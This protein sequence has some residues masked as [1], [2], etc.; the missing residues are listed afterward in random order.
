MWL[1][2][3]CCR[4][5]QI[6]RTLVSPSG[7]CLRSCVPRRLCESLTSSAASLRRLFAMFLA[8]ARTL[9]LEQLW[10]Q[11]AIR[12][13]ARAQRPTRPR[14]RPRCVLDFH[15][16]FSARCFAGRPARRCWQPILCHR[17]VSLQVSICSC[18]QGKGALMRWKRSCPS[19]LHQTR[20]L[21]PGWSCLLMTCRRC[22]CWTTQFGCWRKLFQRQ[23]LRSSLDARRSFK[24]RS[25]LRCSCSTCWEA[26]PKRAAARVLASA[27]LPLCSSKTCSP[28]GRVWPRCARRG[29]R[30]TW[31]SPAS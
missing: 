4:R 26:P 29:A 1:S 27:A 3:T 25:T 31:L 23:P 8:T 18:P 30:A 15:A 2:T 16:T 5:R 19:F 21:L 14:Q 11:L 12:Q 6:V 28:H 24:P 13:A 22:F 9:L 17:T 10:R 20:N 7:T